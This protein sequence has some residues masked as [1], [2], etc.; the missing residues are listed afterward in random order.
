[1][2]IK[3]KKLFEQYKN[4]FLVYEGLICT[5]PLSSIETPVTVRV[6]AP[7]APLATAIA[8]AALA[9]RAVP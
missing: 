7:P 6:L 3:M 4:E 2:N 1:M 8:R 9:F 5:H